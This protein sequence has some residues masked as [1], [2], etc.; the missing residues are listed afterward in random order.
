VVLDVM[1]PKLGGPAIYERIRKEKPDL[2]VIF[3]TGYSPDID[4]LQKVQTEG[5]A[6]LQKPYSP[7]DLARKVRETLDQHVFQQALAT[8]QK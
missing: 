2:P 1:L 4:E 5:L 8:S 7:R 3:A 6:V